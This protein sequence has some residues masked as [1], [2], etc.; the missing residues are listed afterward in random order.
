MWHG[1]E[2]VPQRVVD[3]LFDH[4]YPAIEDFFVDSTDTFLLK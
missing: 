4:F 2:T 3:C 1:Q